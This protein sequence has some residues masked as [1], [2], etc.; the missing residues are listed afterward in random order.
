[1]TETFSPLRARIFLC[2]LPGH[3]FGDLGIHQKVA[4]WILNPSCKG[5]RI[6]RVTSFRF[7]W[8]L[9]K[10]T[11]LRTDLP[12][13]TTY[14]SFPSPDPSFPYKGL[15]W[16]Q[17][18]ADLPS[19]SASAIYLLTKPKTGLYTFYFILASLA[20]RCSVQ[21]SLIGER[22]FQGPWAQQ[23]QHSGL[24]P[25]LPATPESGILVPWPGIKP[26]FPALKG[27]FFEHRTTREIPVYIFFFF[28][29]FISL[30]QVIL[31]A[32]GI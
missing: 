6:I 17:A 32:Y 26:E 5:L 23:L 19:S 8:L 14:T 11:A 28:N 16:S 29:L 2:S 7:W 12:S 18:P 3:S 13:P 9:G 27:R 22:G 15:P 25:P 20:L 1:M 31:V 10:H 30:L 24:V 21:P 4:W